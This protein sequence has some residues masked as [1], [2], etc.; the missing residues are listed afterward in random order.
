MAKDI[1]PGWICHSE[2][3]LPRGLLSSKI[4]SSLR[5]QVSKLASVVVFSPGITDFY[6]FLE[7]LSD[8]KF[9]HHI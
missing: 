8:A 7:F 6:L 5:F 9:G 1:I 3:W 2:Q 4:G